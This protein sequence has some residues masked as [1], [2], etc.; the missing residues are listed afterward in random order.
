[1]ISLALW[2]TVIAL[3]FAVVGMP[4]VLSLAAPEARSR[5]YFSLLLAP[6]CGMSLY[7]GAAVW[8][9][10]F[11]ISGR[12]VF[13]LVLGFAMI[14]TV[15]VL[16][17][18]RLAPSLLIA[19]GG[20][21]IAAMLLG[22]LLNGLD[23]NGLSI[24]DYFPLT[25]DDTFAYLS[26]VD[27]IR[28]IGWNEPRIVYPAGY[29]PEFDYS[30]LPGVAL[31]A[32]LVATFGLPSHTAFFLVQRLSI[33]VIA[34]AA[35]GLAG[36][37]TNSTRAAILCFLLVI[38]G[39]FLL[40]QCLQQFNS[41]TMGG[42]IALPLLW[43][44]GWTLLR[45]NQRSASL[46]GAAL[47]GAFAGFM[48]MA[49]PEGHTLY[50]P[51]LGFLF[52]AVLAVLRQWSIFALLPSF[53]SAYV[54]VTLPLIRILWSQ[55][56]AQADSSPHPGDWIAT[57][58]ILLQYSGVRLVEDRSLLN[59]PTWV[60]AVTLVFAA[61]SMAALVMLLNTAWSA[62]RDGRLRELSLSCVAV[63]GLVFMVTQ[64]GLYAV[65]RG[66]I[67]LKAIDYSSFLPPILI[68]VAAAK[69]LDRSA[70][71]RPQMI[72]AVAI[73]TIW[74]SVV[75]SEK[76]KILSRY[77]ADVVTMPKI[78]DYAIPNRGLLPAVQIFP[79][80]ER[81]VL[82]LFLY[83]NRF[84]PNRIALAAATSNRFEFLNQEKQDPP[85]VARLARTGRA[86]VPIADITGKKL[87]P[88][89]AGLQ[90]SPAVGEVFVQRGDG[91]MDPE[92]DSIAALFRWLGGSGGFVVFGHDH[93]QHRALTIDL[94]PGPDLR[95]A[96]M[97]EI[98]MADQVL[99][100]VPPAQL[101]ATITLPLPLLAGQLLPGMIRILGPQAGPRQ[102]SV[103]SLDT[104]LI[105][106]NE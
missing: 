2:A 11:G 48:A 85:L 44:V 95:S 28:S 74:F 13:V 16:R 88:G 41:S 83:V 57:S 91:W 3:C 40:H 96:N 101:P 39:N 76:G 98:V 87:N 82:N 33:T 56:L 79:D 15:L 92:G 84:G 9:H 61:S 80:F 60:V 104:V 54:L 36:S 105:H 106:P 18:A 24:N 59:Y 102:V 58:A 71:H 72:A 86:G 26:H 77:R 75:Y 23:F 12:V 62:G 38:G 51:A 78:E 70:W 19:G 94:R 47:S 68:A 43:L 10:Y 35:A 1:M 14:A 53:F 25:N 64:I 5:L 99:A 73:A 31:I 63:P 103:V 81:E 21:I 27:Q 67:L 4:L 66:Y 42:V 29:Y 17:A 34:L 8:L 100:T 89:I 55:I 37:L 30:R 69:V 22:T 6:A 45:V 52:V 20:T 32:D 90:L 65:G 97:V 93:S 49:S 50:L 46:L 7:I